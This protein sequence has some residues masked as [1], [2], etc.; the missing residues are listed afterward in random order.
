MLLKFCDKF[1]ILTNKTDIVL[2]LKYI[3]NI[4]E[5][6]KR[7]KNTRQYFELNTQLKPTSRL[8]E[9]DVVSE[10]SSNFG[11]SPALG[12]VLYKVFETEKLGNELLLEDMCKVIDKYR[13]NKPE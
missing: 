2:E 12:P 13:V 6:R 8:K 10:L 1:L 3:A 11:I 7:N 4:L 5:F 9:I